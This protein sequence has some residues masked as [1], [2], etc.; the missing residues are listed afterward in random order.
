M[1]FIAYRFLRHTVAIT[2]ASFLGLDLRLALSPVI[3]FATNGYNGTGWATNIL[4]GATLRVRHDDDKGSVSALSKGSMAGPQ[5]PNDSFDWNGGNSGHHAAIT[6]ADMVIISEGRR[7]R[8]HKAVLSAASV[9][10]TVVL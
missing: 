9:V 3:T 8:C 5:V 4:T 6:A 2:S 10:S 7:I 1:V